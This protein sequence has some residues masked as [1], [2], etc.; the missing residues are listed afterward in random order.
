MSPSDS[1]TP[2]LTPILSLFLLPAPCCPSDINPVLVSSD[3]VEI[4]WSPVRGAELYETKAVDGVNVVECND[5]APACT[6]SALECD[7]KY[8]ITVYS[9]SEV[10]GS[11]TSCAS[12]F[13]TTGTIQ[14]RSFTEVCTAHPSSFWGPL[15]PVLLRGGRREDRR[16]K[17]GKKQ[18]KEETVG[19]VEGF[20]CQPFTF[21]TFGGPACIHTMKVK[22]TDVCLNYFCFWSPKHSL[23][24][25]C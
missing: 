7:T 13:V 23:A 16:G 15:E 5:T 20:A 12:Q 24:F 8:N 21:S 2:G 22:T 25:S 19:M 4:V 11:N 9:F 6:L 14:H 17:L 10:R 1:I 3:R 18:T